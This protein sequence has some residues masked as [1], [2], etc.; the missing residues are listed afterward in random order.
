MLKI[1]RIRRADARLLE[2]VERLLPQLSGA[3]RCPSLQELERVASSRTAALFGAEADGRIVGM[4][5]MAW[6]DVP[7]GR[8]AWIEDVVVDAGA[9]GCGIGEAL[10]QAALSQARRIGATTV[11]LTSSPARTAAHALYRKAGFE[12]YETTVFRRP[13]RKE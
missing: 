2:A 8:R 13:P 1:V 11:S 5:T 3:L 6:Y 12:V 7:S 4:L 9:R 10:V